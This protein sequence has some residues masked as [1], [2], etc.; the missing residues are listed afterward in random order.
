MSFLSGAIHLAGDVAAPVAEG[1][2]AATS[3]GGLA[4]S[5]GSAYFTNVGHA[6]SN[7]NVTL[8][9][10][11]GLIG[12]NSAFQYHA[13]AANA[14]SNNPGSASSNGQVLG[15]RTANTNTYG[16]TATPG[17]LANG[18]SVNNPAYGMYAGNA[19]D[20][21]GEA[22]VSSLNLDDGSILFCC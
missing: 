8:S 17:Q 13:P 14:S 7:P 4:N 20:A 15:A 11:G 19:Q 16:T 3:L 2:G 12:N 21:L 1:I 5:G 22:G 6:I 18:D 9:N 10:P